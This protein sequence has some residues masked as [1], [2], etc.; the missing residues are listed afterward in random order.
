MI[1]L[2][3]AVVLELNEIKLTKEK[4]ALLQ[5]SER[6]AHSVQA[7]LLGQFKITAHGGTIFQESLTPQGQ[8]LL[9]IKL[10]NPEKSF[11]P[12]D[13]YEII[14]QGKDSVNPS[15]VVSSALYRLRVALDVSGLKQLIIHLPPSSCNSIMPCR[16]RKSWRKD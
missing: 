6:P 3:Y 7:C 10:L 9:T 1:V 14:N 15:N 5:I 16:G 8:V 2:S 12:N 13:L 4:V 11:T